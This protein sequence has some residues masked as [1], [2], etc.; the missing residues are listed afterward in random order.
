MI[1]Q[2]ILLTIEWK[3]YPQVMEDCLNSIAYQICIKLTFSGQ[4]VNP[5]TVKPHS[6]EIPPIKMQ[7]HI[8]SI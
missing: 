5:N 3:I 1:F 4:I 8:P 2:M 6:Y 7:I